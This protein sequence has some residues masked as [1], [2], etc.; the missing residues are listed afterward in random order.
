MHCYMR[1]YPLELLDSLLGA[2]PLSS[3][4]GMSQAG[5][6]SRGQVPS[7][8]K[9]C[10]SGMYRFVFVSSLPTARDA[11]LCSYLHKLEQN[12]QRAHMMCWDCGYGRLLDLVELLDSDA[13]DRVAATGRAASGGPR[14]SREDPRRE[15]DDEDA[16]DGDGSGL[17]EDGGGRGASAVSDGPAASDGNGGGQAVAGSSHASGASESSVS[18]D[19]DGAAQTRHGPAAWSHHSRA[20]RME[21]PARG[22]RASPGLAWPP[23]PGSRLEADYGRRKRPRSC[24]S[25]DSCIACGAAL[26][27]QVDS[28]RTGGSEGPRS[29]ESV[30][31]SAEPGPR[32]H[33]IAG[34]REL[35][36]HHSLLFARTCTAIP[37]CQGKLQPG[38]RYDFSMD[39][40]R[41]PTKCTSTIS[42][43]QWPR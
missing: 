17:R 16:G 32:A 40:A 34:L 31:D 10:R 35:L 21:P 23:P 13:R 26:L 24:T 6:G 14:R 18:R 2:G 4:T 7:T 19:H 28:A 33:R 11:Q 41:C 12:L 39:L 38:Q 37:S 20:G 25:E 8:H 5:P 22:R 3:A 27:L 15:D 1:C 42:S 43:S 30:G 36:A 9:H 29:N